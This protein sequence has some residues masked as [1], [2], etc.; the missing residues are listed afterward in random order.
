M[1][2]GADYVAI[3]SLRRVG[4][5][6]EMARQLTSIAGEKHGIKPQIIAKIERAEAV[7]K[8][9][10][11]LEAVRRHHGGAR[12]SRRSRSARPAPSCKRMFA[13]ARAPASRSSLRRT[14]WS[15]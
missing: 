12:R 14:S 11:I 10:E 7:G 5:D 8:L 9:R 1:Q 4:T 2:C 3:S 13:P 6:V 15:R